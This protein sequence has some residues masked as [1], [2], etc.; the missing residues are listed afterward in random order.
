MTK[1]TLTELEL[2]KKLNTPGFHL[3]GNL[4]EGGSLYLKIEKSKTSGEMLRRWVL[5]YYLNGK[6]YMKGLKT[7]KERPLLSAIRKAASAYMQGLENGV[8]V[9]KQAPD[10]PVTAA[11][12]V[13]TLYLK[14]LA[15]LETKKNGTGEQV[16]RIASRF[17][18]HVLPTLGDK[19]PDSITSKDIADAL[20]KVDG[21]QSTKAKVKQHINAF[22]KWARG[23]G[24]MDQ[25]R[26]GIASAEALS[27][28]VQEGGTA[29]HH[30][31]LAPAEIPRFIATLT[32]PEFIERVG[33]LALLFAVLNC[34]RAGMIRGRP[35][36]SVKPLTWKQISRKKDGRTILH[37]KAE[38]MKDKDAG[39]FEIIL[40]RQSV[41]LL[42]YVK[43]L[44]LSNASDP[45]AVVF[46]SKHGGP[47]CE[48][49]MN[50]S[51]KALDAFDLLNGGPGF[52]DPKQTAKP[53]KDQPKAKPEKK[54][55]TQHGV[56]RASFRTWAADTHPEQKDIAET[57]LAHRVL[58]DQ[59]GGAY[60]RSGYDSARAE[61]LQEWAD[62]CFSAC[63]EHELN[64]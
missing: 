2:K 63:P 38:Q 51:I 37:V 25:L 58:G 42:E 11:P 17:R 30:P 44:H 47:I 26:I 5:R 56:S 59:Y 21:K 33:T 22:L 14:W 54:I 57:C 20:N 6:R 24:N 28:F 8:D 62:Y 3:V 55:A 1:R 7:Y 46:P 64:K 13:K 39:D 48:N 15:D 31:F 18:N 34:A 40:S 60:N 36:A 50:K 23:S 52:R 29:E 27:P 19:E 45:D 16:S 41:N 35:E 43:T 9:R 53:K 12:T 49:T 4:P 61:L 32:R 10:I